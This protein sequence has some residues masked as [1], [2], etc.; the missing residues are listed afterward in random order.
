LAG[1]GTSGPGVWT[2]SGGSATADA[3]NAQA[4][5]PLG[6]GTTPFFAYAAAGGAITANFVGGIVGLDILWGSPDGYN[7]ITFYTGPNRT[8]TAESF[9]P[10]TPPLV[11]PAPPLVAPVLFTA[12]P[13]VTW[14]SVSFT[15]TF[16][17]FEFA[18]IETVASAPEP[19]GLALVLGG[20]LAIAAIRRSI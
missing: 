6:S 4:F 1:N 12:A 14:E 17:A 10:G 3:S 13:G 15:S 5:D 20:V 8:G 18:N 11:A 9:V 19:G 2:F 16:N 7:T